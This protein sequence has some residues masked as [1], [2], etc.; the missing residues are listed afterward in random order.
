M[1]FTMNIGTA[2]SGQKDHSD[3]I[4]PV[5]CLDRDVKSRISLASVSTSASASASDGS[6]TP[7]QDPFAYTFE[8]PPALTLEIP[9][10][11]LFWPSLPE[12]D[13]TPE[14]LP[15]L[16]ASAKP[17]LSTSG[18]T[19]V[20]GLQGLTTIPSAP[21][22]GLQGLTTIPS[23]PAKGTSGVSVVPKRKLAKVQHTWTCDPGSVDTQMSIEEGTFVYVWSESTTATGWVYAESLI[24]STRAGWLPASMLQQLPPNKCWMR[25]SK[26]CR[27]IYPTQ[28]PV[29]AGNMILIDIS[30][31]P[32]GDG[33]VYAEQLGSATGLQVAEGC[34]TAGWVPI[35]CI[36]WAEV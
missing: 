18:T 17:V 28:M 22:K 25:V 21:A 12:T 8:M 11:P 29:E 15:S 27:A 20:M 30:Q 4:V 3:D 35:Q 24:C 36:K 16:D 13:K 19:N 14:S 7:Q 26:Q 32:V 31:T 10:V 34:C 1:L 23:A 6:S 9:P 5:V 2:G 33:W